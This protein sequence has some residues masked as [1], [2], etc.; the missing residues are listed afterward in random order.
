MR[1]CV[2]GIVYGN[3]GLGGIAR[4]WTE[5]IREFNRPGSRDCMELVIP[6]KAKTIP[7]LPHSRQLSWPA[8]RTMLAADIYHTSY[9]SIWPRMRCVPVVTTV[10][11]WI[12]AD[13]PHYYSNGV[14][15][16][17]AQ[18]S[19]IAKSDGLVVISEDVRRL[20]IGHTRFPEERIEVAYPAVGGVFASPLPSDFDTKSFRYAHTGGAPYFLHVGRRN[21]YKNF[22]TILEG[23]LAI[24]GKTDRHLLVV[25]G[26]NGFPD[27]LA[28]MVF[29]AG[30][31][32]KVN[33][34]PYV[35]DADLRIAYAASDGF[36]SASL[37]EGFGIPLLEALAS[38]AK[39]VVSDIPVYHE[40][41]GDMADY[42]PP[43]DPEAWAD[44]MLRDHPWKSEFRDA[45]LE[46]Y[47]WEKTAEAHLRLYRK[48]LGR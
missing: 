37:G 45:V 42:L 33:I 5:T 13:L 2:D 47:T 34:L 40:V 20:T 8:L 46:K 12:T 15:F 11:D 27:D 26:E 16:V 41:A 36:L 18:K 48:L 28:H 9:Y 38:G 14:G 23:Y 32:K 29:R 7:R 35:S 44:A 6:K 10:Y 21:Y 19:A 3:N 17:N 43:S 39:P 24:A 1:I 4:Y 31:E 22:R 25:G 30:A